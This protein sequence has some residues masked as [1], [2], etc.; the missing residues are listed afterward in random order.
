MTIF[1]IVFCELIK[2][3]TDLF[4]CYYMHRRFAVTNKLHWICIINNAKFKRIFNP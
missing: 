3:K 1:L 4:D 2:E